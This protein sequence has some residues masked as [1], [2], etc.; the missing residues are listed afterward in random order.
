MNK[1]GFGRQVGADPEYSHPAGGVGILLR[2]PFRP[3]LHDPCTDEYEEVFK[4]GRCSIYAV[5]YAEQRADFIIVYCSAGGRDGNDACKRA[6]GMLNVI[7]MEL[8]LM[9]KV[10]AFLMGDLNADIEDLEGLI[11]WMKDN[12]WT[13]IGGTSPSESRWSEPSNVPGLCGGK[14]H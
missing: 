5:E 13:D 10:P 3:I 7:S 8:E 11:Q 9:E 2:K 12:A 1:A 14:K 6:G 4:T